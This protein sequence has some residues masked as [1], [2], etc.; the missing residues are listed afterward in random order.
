MPHG[1]QLSEVFP[2]L[3]ELTVDFRKTRFISFIF[4]RNEFQATIITKSTREGK[5]SLN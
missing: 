3:L 1:N 2:E 4:A 5:Y